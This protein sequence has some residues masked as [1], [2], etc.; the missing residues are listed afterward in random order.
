MALSDSKNKISGIVNDILSESDNK[1]INVYIKQLNIYPRRDIVNCWLEELERASSY[2]KKGKILSHLSAY[3]D[4]RVVLPVAKY[5]ISRYQF[6]RLNA[7]KSLKKM[8]D[9]R[10]YPIVLKMAKSSNPVH[11]IYFIEAMNYLYDRRFYFALSRMMNDPNKSVRIY[12]LNCVVKNNIKEAVHFV[13]K[14]AQGDA[15]NEV[16]IAAIK[17]LGGFND[18]SSAY[19][20]HKTLND[21]N[22]GIRRESA[23]ALLKIGSPVSV[24]ALSSRLM[25][26]RD[27]EIKGLLLEALIKIKRSGNVRN[28]EKVFTT[29][30][31]IRLKIKTAYLL[32]LAGSQ[33]AATILMNGLKDNDYRVK[34]EICNSLGNYR[35][36]QVLSS[37]LN[38]LKNESKRYVKSAALFSI[39]RINDRSAVV[40][41]FDIYTKEKDPIFRNILKNI[42]REYIDIYL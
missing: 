6:V 14:A 37:L 10:L 3:N 4:R 27:D 5:L 19:L 40:V 41:L 26:E 11:K 29:D 18:R 9:D 33:L 35:N 2:R 39:K 30:R 16:R 32:G 15:N 12:V 17:A 22:R 1:R 42:I 8:G 13:R 38:V 20:V 36:R 21:S 25:L 28:L 31:N 24:N 23:K 34:A 7:A